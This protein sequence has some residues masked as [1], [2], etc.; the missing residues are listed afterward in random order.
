MT[1]VLVVPG[2]GVVVSGLPEVRSV[3]AVRL[4]FVLMM[5]VVMHGTPHK[6]TSAA[7]GADRQG[8]A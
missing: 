6:G 1:S 3:P 5:A 7:T 8:V 2:V 4:M